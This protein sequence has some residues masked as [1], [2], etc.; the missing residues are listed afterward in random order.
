[1]DFSGIFNKTVSTLERSLNIRSR[2]HEVITSNLANADTP[3]YK[4]FDL[5][6]NEEV[7]RGEDRGGTLKLATTDN[8]HMPDRRQVDLSPK[9]KKIELPKGISLRGDGNTVDM[10]REMAKLTENDL[11]YRASAQ[12]L[13]S[14]FTGLKNAIQGGRK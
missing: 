14:K 11:M 4:A 5:V 2:K 8:G 3:N 12:I 6:F 13:A 10:D 7:A 1:M 9:L